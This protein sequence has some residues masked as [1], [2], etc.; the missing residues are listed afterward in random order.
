M[1]EVNSEKDID[2][3]TQ[4][5]IIWLDFDGGGDML[6]TRVELIRLYDEI[7]RIVGDDWDNDT[8]IR[9]AVTVVSSSNAGLYSYLIKGYGL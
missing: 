7:A 8:A 1:I 2:K 3:N 6:I 9:H 5:D 4:C